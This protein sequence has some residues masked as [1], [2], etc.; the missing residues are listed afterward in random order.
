MLACANTI[1]NIKIFW[2]QCEH[3]HRSGKMS[4]EYRLTL[5]C[6]VLFHFPFRC[7]IYASSFSSSFKHN[8]YGSPFFRCCWFILSLSISVS[9]SLLVC[10][11]FIAIFH[12]HT[13]SKLVCFVAHLLVERI[14]LE[15]VGSWIF[16]LV[17]VSFVTIDAGTI[18]KPNRNPCSFLLRNHQID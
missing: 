10:V 8:V 6:A 5:S 11:H 15:R 13:K 12:N 18:T 4:L 7:Y 9:L 17:W 16:C 3:V 2:V 1:A 14:K